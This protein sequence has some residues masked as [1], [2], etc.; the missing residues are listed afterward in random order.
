MTAPEPIPPA[1]EMHPPTSSFESEIESSGAAAGAA[2]GTV[3]ATASARPLG[4]HGLRTVVQALRRFWLCSVFYVL[5]FHLGMMSLTW[6]LVCAMLYPLL[7]RATGLVLGRAAIS[8]VYRGFW[9]TTRW[10]GLMSID[11]ESLDALKDDG[12]LIIAANHPSMF[13]AMLVIARV[14][15]GICIMR[16]SLMRSLFIGPGA[17]LA[18]YIRNDPPRGMVRSCIENL[19]A[20]GQLVLFPEGTRTVRSPINEFRPGITL[21]AHLAE[22]PIQTVIIESQ[23]PYLGKGWP[24]WRPP[25]FPVIVS[26]RLGRRFQPEADYNGLLIRLESYFAAELA[27]S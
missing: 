24:I 16:A 27:A 6:N 2:A 22:V 1:T 21:I 12:G 20:G 17:R 25:Q 13:D 18:R 4:E 3:A 11:S 8:S 19:K 5:L 10:L 14:P 7:P 9:S 26:A 15:R 23:S